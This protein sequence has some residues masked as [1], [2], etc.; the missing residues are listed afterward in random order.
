MIFSVIAFKLEP[1]FYLSLGLIHEINRYYTQR[2]IYDIYP[3]IYIP[4]ALTVPFKAPDK[5]NLDSTKKMK[6]L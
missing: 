1:N 3:A 6:Y 2:Y 5:K 4:S